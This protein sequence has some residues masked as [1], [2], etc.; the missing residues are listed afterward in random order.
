MFGFR[1]N[2]NYLFFCTNISS[3]NKSGQN[4]SNNKKKITNFYMQ[5]TLTHPERITKP[6]SFVFEN[7]L[8]HLPFKIIH[9]FLNY[10]QHNTFNIICLQVLYNQKYI[11]FSS[12]LSICFGIFCPFFCWILSSR[13]FSFSLFWL[14]FFIWAHSAPFVM[15]LIMMVV[16]KIT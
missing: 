11:S 12:L 7:E 3:S 16:E 10:H 8:H 4:Q 2:S 5:I 15:C 13:Y 6:L 1:L 14:S 9:I